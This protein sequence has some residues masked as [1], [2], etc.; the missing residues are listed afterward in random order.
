MKKRY[1]CLSEFYCYS[2][3]FETLTPREAAEA[4][5]ESLY[6]QQQKKEHYFNVLVTEANNHFSDTWDFSVAIKPSIMVKATLFKT[7]K[8]DKV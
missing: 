3:T 1:K 4:L 5:A 6:Y 7:T 8:S 2:D